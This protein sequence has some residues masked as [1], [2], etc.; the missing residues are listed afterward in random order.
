MYFE[1]ITVKKIKTASLMAIF[2]LSMVSSITAQI[3]D[4]HNMEIH[5]VLSDG[6]L[7]ETA[8]EYP[9]NQ[10]DQK[11]IVIFARGSGNGDMSE[12]ADG[13]FDIFL[14]NT[15]LAKGVAIV[16]QNKRGIGK[17][18]GNWKYGSIEQRAD[19]LITVA[20]Y[21]RESNDV[22]TSIVGIVG[23]SQGGW[24]VLEAGARD[25]DLDFVIS[26]AGPVV[27]VAKAHGTNW[28]SD[29]DP[30]IW[31]GAQSQHF[32]WSST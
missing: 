23:H 3:R 7:L 9:S 12:Y 1:I 17:S 18:T 2:L 21:Y 8:I 16:Y 29:P 4:S 14:R 24:V 20:N 19:D 13:F 27:S 31:W 30:E 10:I 22:D 6:V 32:M 26:M 28:C 25:P 15:F 11:G 5:M